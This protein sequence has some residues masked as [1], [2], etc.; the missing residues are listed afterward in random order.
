MYMI[1]LVNIKVKQITIQFRL[2]NI[3]GRELIKKMKNEKKLKKIELK[4][5]YY[6]LF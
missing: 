5:I 2:K 4:F 6:I 3:H 1:I